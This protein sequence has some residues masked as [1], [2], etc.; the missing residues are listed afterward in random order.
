MTD[1][2]NKVHQVGTRGVTVAP[3]KDATKPIYTHVLYLKQIFKDI[4]PSIE[5]LK[6]VIVYAASSVIPGGVFVRL[7]W[8]DGGYIEFNICDTCDDLSM[9]KE[10]A[11]E[12]I[13]QYYEEYQRAFRE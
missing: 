8:S 2:S 4:Q 12:L 6:D 3:S 11:I 13:G 9:T 1:K 7:Y 5:H 10:R